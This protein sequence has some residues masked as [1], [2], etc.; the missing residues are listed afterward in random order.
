MLLDRKGRFICSPEKQRIGTGV[1]WEFAE[2]FKGQKGYFF[3]RIGREPMFV[4]Y[5]R[6]ARSNWLLISLVPLSKLQARIG[7]IRKNTVIALLV[8]F[9]FCLLISYFVFR[10]L[11]SP[12]R[13]I[14]DSFKSLQEGSTDR[15]MRL[16]DAS[17]DEIGDLSR[18][19]NAF[20]ENVESKKLIEDE[21]LKSRE[22][23]RSLVDNLREVIFQMDA[24]GR[25]TFL[26]PAW[27]EITGFPVEESIGN[28]FLDYVHPEDRE[29]LPETL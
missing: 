2:K 6:A 9:A 10:K 19:F 27:T 7:D 1:S 4:T 12:I 14:T 23:Y 5:Q 17:R 15:K 20:V 16:S 21:L 13:K 18:G 8:C 3:D 28:S 29:L 26:N 22:Q 24:G 25:W 11:V